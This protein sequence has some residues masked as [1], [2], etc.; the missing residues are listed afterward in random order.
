MN[1]EMV[2]LAERD[3][4]EGSHATTRCSP[5]E[6]LQRM[7]SAFDEVKTV[8]A[9]FSTAW[10]TFSPQLD[11]A[12]RLADQTAALAEQ[13]GDPD[14]RDL[15]A[16]QRTLANVTAVLSTDPLSIRAEDIDRGPDLDTE[17]TAIA[18]LAGSGEWREA[19]REL[20]EWTV[21]TSARLN[22]AKQALRASRAPIEARNQLRALLEAYQ[23]KAARLGLIEDPRLERLFARAREALYVAPT[24]L[25]VAAPLVRVYQEALL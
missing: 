5:D 7:S 1:R 2:P 21:R 12:R 18:A 23:V 15:D 16:A 10:E 6:L 8:V 25:G 9:R 13:L 19:R 11:W 3:L 24:D 20:Q 14:R 22:E 17:L 4:L